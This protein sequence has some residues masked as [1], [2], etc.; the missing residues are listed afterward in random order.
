[1]SFFQTFGAIS[2]QVQITFKQKLREDQIRWILS[3]VK[4][5]FSISKV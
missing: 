5:K 1:M 2:Y 3:I 4:F